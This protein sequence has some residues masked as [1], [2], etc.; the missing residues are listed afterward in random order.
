MSEACGFRVLC[1]V[2]AFV[3]MPVYVANEVVIELLI[4]EHVAFFAF[5][6]ECF[7]QRR[8]ASSQI[9][10]FYIVITTGSRRA[11]AEP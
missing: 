9:R 3:V 1:L 5:K 7:D 10:A 8:D 6:V 2:K 4:G 11:L